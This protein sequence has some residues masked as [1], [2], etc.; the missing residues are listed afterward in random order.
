VSLLG[1]SVDG[2]SSDK[3]EAHPV[4]LADQSQ[5]HFVYAYVHKEHARSYD[6]IFVPNSVTAN[7]RTATNADVQ[8]FL[9]EARQDQIAVIAVGAARERLTAFP[10]NTAFTVPS[11]EEVMNWVFDLP[12]AVKELSSALSASP[13]IMN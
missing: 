7:Y 13:S 2:V 12:Q 9:R 3:S 6:A 8:Q 1:V 5:S 4:E 11:D 10:R